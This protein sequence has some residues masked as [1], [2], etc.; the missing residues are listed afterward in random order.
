MLNAV[1]ALP[2][3]ARLL[4]II[5]LLVST[6]SVG[7]ITGYSWQTT[8]IPLEVKEPIEI[9]DYPPAVS[10][11]PGENET[12]T[13]TVQNLASVNYSASLDFSL[14]DTTYQKAYVAFSNKKYTILPGKQTLDAWL[15]VA[16]EAPSGTFLITVSVIREGEQVPANES[17]PS[18]SAVSDLSPSLTLLGAG[19]RWAA[20]SGSSA[21]VITW[22]ENWVAHHLT[23]GAY[24]GPWPDESLMDNQSLSIT[25][26]L[27]QAGF[28]VEYAGDMPEN[29]NGYDLIVIQ[30][31]FAIEPRHEALLRDYVF[32]GGSVVIL[33]GV[34]CYFSTY[35][36]DW[37]PGGGALPEWLGRG[38]YANDGGTATIIVNNPFGTQFSAGSTVFYSASFSNAAT[39]SLNDNVTVVAQWSSGAAFAY[40]ME[41]GKG[42][43]YYQANF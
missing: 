26:A 1:K 5:V 12:L 38:F 41:Y 14:N 24:W 7:I 35:C 37:W 15:T 39:I 33:S 2:R 20:G 40:T 31:Y 36:K 42:R 30:A 11:F 16:P 32:G 10:L 13:V 34:P 21:L 29:P 23:D 4:C 25:S 22:K 9:L 43:V 3:K 8:S 19:A 6:S 18:S 17:S 27:E 28:N